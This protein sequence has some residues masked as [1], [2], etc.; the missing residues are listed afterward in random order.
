MLHLEFGKTYMNF[1]VGQRRTVVWSK[2]KLSVWSNEWGT[3]KH[4]WH[5]STCTD[6]CEHDSIIHHWITIRNCPILSHQNLEAVLN[7][8]G[9]HT[10]SVLNKNLKCSISL[11]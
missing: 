8:D 3:A 5:Q 1:T 7:A 9:R 10:K 4:S 6:K 11:I 2:K